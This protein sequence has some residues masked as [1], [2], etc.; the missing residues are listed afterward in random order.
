MEISE[1]QFK[2]DSH[3]SLTGLAK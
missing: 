2:R 1:S 3:C